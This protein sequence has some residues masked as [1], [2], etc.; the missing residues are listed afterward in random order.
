M[1]PN[2]S[3]FLL[4]IDSGTKISTQNTLK[5]VLTITFLKSNVLTTTFLN[6]NS[7]QTLPQAFKWKDSKVYVT[8]LADDNCEI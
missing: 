1:I 3:S 6:N 8:C 2:I 5:L 7:L 4:W